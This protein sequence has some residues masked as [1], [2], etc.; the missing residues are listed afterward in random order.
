M[1]LRVIDLFCGAG[2][3]S[4][5]FR[6][7][8]FKVTHAVDNWNPAIETHRANQP[9]TEAVKA[10]IESLDP[11]RFPRP[12]V[13]IGGPPCQEFSGSKLGGGGDVA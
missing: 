2:G 1:T 4:E 7:M 12:D 13:L 10:D 11:R 6:H 5:G 9:E 3:F 8:G